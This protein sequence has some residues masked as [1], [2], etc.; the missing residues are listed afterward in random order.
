MLDRDVDS[1][2]LTTNTAIGRWNLWV[3][4]VC[5][6]ILD[7]NRF[8]GVTFC[9]VPSGVND[10]VFEHGLSEWRRRHP[11][12]VSEDASGSGADSAE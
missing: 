8:A 1:Y 3:G 6:R 4:V 9:S 7:A 11:E 2:S 12:E 5:S 10:R